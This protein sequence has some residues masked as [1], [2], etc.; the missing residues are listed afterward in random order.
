VIPRH[1][2]PQPDASGYLYMALA[3]SVLGLVFGLSMVTR[4]IGPASIPIW[5]V[6]FVTLIFVAN[7]P[8]GK[9]LGRRISGDPAES[10]PRLDVPDEVYAELDELRARMV[11]MEE[12]QDFSERLLASRVDGVTNAERGGEG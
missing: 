7:G 2:P 10:Q 6:S 4:A 5:G 3:F 9:A 8:I 12:R 11:E 1:D